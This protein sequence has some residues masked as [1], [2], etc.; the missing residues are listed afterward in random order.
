MLDPCEG[1]GE[2]ELGLTAGEGVV[3]PGETADGFRCGK[4]D[5]VEDER[6]GGSEFRSGGMM[7][8]MMKRTRWSRAWSFVKLELWRKLGGLGSGN[9][10]RDESAYRGETDHMI[11]PAHKIDTV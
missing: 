7:I 6:D 9:D 10:H 11:E 4:E 3:V 8:D 1:R 2:L 5:E